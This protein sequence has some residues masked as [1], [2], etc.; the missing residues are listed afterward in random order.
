[1]DAPI[2]L[3]RATLADR[4]TIEALQAAA[5]ASVA[6]LTERT[7]IPLMWDYGQKLKDWDVW[8]AEDSEGLTGVLML[9][10]R[11]DDLFLES[12]AVHPRMQGTGLGNKLLA[13]T[14]A[15][16]LAEG[17]SIVRL[18]T[19]EKNVDRIALYKRRGYAIDFIEETTD[20]RAV[21]MIKHLT[22]S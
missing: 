2:G 16:A 5:Y 9:H 7:P 19:N 10:L 1:M 12:I 20:R 6:I 14:D 11:P 15:A 8:L 21:H 17:R 22:K 18:M 13:A 3:R 4:A